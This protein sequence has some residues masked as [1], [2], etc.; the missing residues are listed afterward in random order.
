MFHH[1]AKNSIKIF[2][3]SITSLSISWAEKICNQ[4]KMLKLKILRITCVTLNP[5]NMSEYYRQK[6]I[7]QAKKIFSVFRKNICCFIPRGQ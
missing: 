5:K 4:L 3:F 7:S 2:F 1:N 6:I